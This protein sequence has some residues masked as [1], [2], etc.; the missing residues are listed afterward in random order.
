[1]KPGILALLFIFSF[2]LFAQ[3]PTAADTLPPLA[4]PSYSFVLPVKKSPY[5]EAGFTFGAIASSVS[6]SSILHFSSSDFITNKDKA[7][8][9][10]DVGNRLRFGYT[11][12]IMFGYREPWYKVFDTYKTGQGFGIRNRYYSSA[13]ASK[14]LLKL[15]LY[16]NKPFAGQTLKL[17]GSTFESWYLTSLDYHFDV[18]LDSVQPISLTVSIQVGHDHSLYQVN[19]GS[20]YTDP[21]GAFLDLALDYRLRDRELGTQALAGLGV[22]LGGESAFRLTDR[23]KL[24]LKVQDAG[25]MNWN[26][27]RLLD[28]DSTFR[29]RGVVYDNIFD[30]SDS[31]TRHNSDQF[32]KSFLYKKKDSYIRPLP[33]YTEVE[34]ALKG[35]K[36]LFREWF[37]RGDYR[38]LPGY[39]P[40]LTVGTVLRTGYKQDLSVEASG[41]GFTLFGINAGYRFE[42]GRYLD[43]QLR[44]ENLNG[45]LVP[46]VFGGAIVQVGA[47]YDL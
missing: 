27:G 22:S 7:D 43:L 36:R 9:L 13:T 8:L 2:R 17:D 1:M 15:L 6:T 20:L 12:E 33:F 23:S 37:V 26:N 28:T 42:W 39:L 5:I 14:D 46:G 10:S 4:Q 41:G 38:Y 47:S 30:I 29:F 44:V 32:R 24:T 40:R 45:L 16:G 34:W 31:L 21:D 25:I 35:E 18:L 3:E 19:Q 11:R